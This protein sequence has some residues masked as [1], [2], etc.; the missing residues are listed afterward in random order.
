MDENALSVKETNDGGFIITGAWYSPN[1]GIYLLKTDSQG[2]EIWKKT[3][4]ETRRGNVVLEI[5]DGGF[6]V[7]GNSEGET[8]YYIDGYLLHTDSMGIK[9]WE[10]IHG[11][12]INCIDQTNDGGYILGCSHTHKLLLI[13]TDE[14]GGK[15]WEKV[16]GNRR[17]ERPI[18][19]APPTG[20]AERRTWIKI[21][22]TD[23]DGDQVFYYV[24]WGDGW[25][26][27]EW[28]GPYDSGKT[29]SLSHIYIEE[30]T[31]SE[32]YWINVNCKDINN[33]ES[34]CSSYH[35]IQIDKSRSINNPFTYQL[36]QFFEKWDF[37]LLTRL[38][39]LL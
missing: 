32:D 27:P 14:D 18:I 15:I 17:P 9:K 7:A 21:S 31:W 34:Y 33:E 23:P 25:P 4:P 2:N 11:E 16:Y 19:E 35:K 36:K 22:T 8:G 6:I 26:E 28:I 37:P 12:S 5:E 20:K 30:S 38:I 3:Y 39:H 13:K 1:G 24:D 29:V 10:K